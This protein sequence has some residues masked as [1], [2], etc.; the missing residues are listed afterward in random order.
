MLFP[1][2]LA[3][4]LSRR[5]PASNSLDGLGVAD[6]APALPS[7]HGSMSASDDGASDHE[8]DAGSVHFESHDEEL[9]PELPDEEEGWHQEELP[10]A[11]IQEELQEGDSEGDAE[12]GEAGA[13]AERQR[14]DLLKVASLRDDANLS[15][16]HFARL[17]AMC[18]P[19]MEGLPRSPFLFDKALEDLAYARPSAEAV[20]NLLEVDISIGS[21][22]SVLRVPP[23][24]LG[25]RHVFW[26]R[27]LRPII[28]EIVAQFGRDMV[29]DIGPETRAAGAGAAAAAPPQE[30]VYGFPVSGDA[31]IAEAAFLDAVYEAT[32]GKH[33][34]LLLGLYADKTHR[35]TIGNKAYIPLYLTFFN[36]HQDDFNS[37][38]SKAR[39]LGMSADNSFGCHCSWK[40]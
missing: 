31:A 24:L 3:M 30:R 38:D 2:T 12:D 37:I 34:P 4:A 8:S 14:E 32:R 7:P 39:S 19:A 11:E 9:H 21:G 13:G 26:Q 17:L 23:S 29:F 36:L 33:V 35:P 25:Q 18:G 40:V 15:R 10:L 28:K 16:P 5:G 6:G 27:K 1:L 22:S 20:G